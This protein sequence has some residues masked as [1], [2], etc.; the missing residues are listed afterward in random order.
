M[1]RDG[2]S[3]CPQRGER[4]A[5]APEAPRDETPVAQE[6]DEMGETE[7]EEVRLRGEGGR[8]E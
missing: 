5:K 6:G 2:R 1:Q 8:E 7:V 3:Q 4:R